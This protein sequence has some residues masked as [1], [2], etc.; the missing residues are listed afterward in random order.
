VETDDVV[1]CPYCDKSCDYETVSR[2]AAEVK[3]KQ[4]GNAAI[5]FGFITVVIG[6]LFVFVFPIAGIALIVGGIAGAAV[7]DDAYT[8]G[9]SS[10]GAW[11]LGTFLLFIIVLPLY[12]YHR[13]Y[14]PTQRRRPTQE[15]D[16]RERVRFATKCECGHDI[17][18][19]TYVGD[20]L[21]CSQCGRKIRVDGGTRILEETIAVPTST[22]FCRECAAKIPRDSKFCKECGTKLIT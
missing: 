16:E 17:D 1:T 8:C 4:S 10:P 11:A 14:G 21:K 18:V 9:D 2:L 5:F 13:A 15:S 19:D 12:L 20:P 3:S 22:M 6:I 7:Y